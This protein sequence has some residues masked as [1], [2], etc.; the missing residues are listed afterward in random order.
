MPRIKELNI[1]A[2]ETLQDFSEIYSSGKNKKRFKLHR[3]HFWYKQ[4]NGYNGLVNIVELHIE[5][6]SY[7]KDIVQAE[8]IKKKFYIICLLAMKEAYI[9]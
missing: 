9:S 7:L 1:N 5:L 3:N 4:V 2:N 6:E 8:N